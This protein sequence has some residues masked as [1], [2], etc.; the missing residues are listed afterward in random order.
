[1]NGF[2]NGEGEGPLPG[3]PRREKKNDT[4]SKQTK[5]A[6]QY[7]PQGKLF[8]KGYGPE[9]PK[10]D[11]DTLGKSTVDLA[12]DLMEAGEQAGETLRQQ[13]VPAAQRDVVG[14][15]YKNLTP[16]KGEPKKAKP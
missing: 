3:G 1:M 10:P 4:D 9:M 15:F 11:K 6:G 12:P 16:Q 13:K 14:E 8:M 7:N 2:G 5:D